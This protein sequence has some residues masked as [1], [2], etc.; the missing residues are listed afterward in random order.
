VQ[1]LFGRIIIE[2]AEKVRVIFGMIYTTKMATRA[3]KT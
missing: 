3:A 1:E 2:Y